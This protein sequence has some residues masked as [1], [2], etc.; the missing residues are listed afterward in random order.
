SG[1]WAEAGAGAR[2]GTA[3]VT[4]EPCDHTGRTGPCSQA[5][6]SAGVSRVVYAQPDLGQLAG[7]GATTLLEAG[8]EVEGGL[9]AE[10]AAALNPEWTFAV[11]HGRPFVTWKL[12]ASLDGRSAAADGTSRWITGPQARADV[13]RLRASVDAVLV[14]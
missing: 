9:L 14:G 11:T 10:L 6:R 3:V 4:R 8:V 7:G 1:A 12:A 5:L 13:H 2:G